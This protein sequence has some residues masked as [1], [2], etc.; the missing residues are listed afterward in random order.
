[1]YRH[2]STDGQTNDISIK[3]AHELMDSISN[4]W[5]DESTDLGKLFVGVFDWDYTSTDS[6]IELNIPK[7]AVGGEIPL[8]EAATKEFGFEIYGDC[9]LKLK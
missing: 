6:G 7:L 2:Y 4:Q 5:E 3:E 1:M 8:N 9:F